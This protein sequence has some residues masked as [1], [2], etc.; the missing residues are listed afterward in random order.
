MIRLACMDDIEYLGSMVKSARDYMHSNGN[1][2]QWNGVY[3][4]VDD[5]KYHIEKGDLYV[6]EI[7]DEI[8]FAFVFSLE[9]DPNYAYIEDGNWLNEEPYGVFHL[10]MSSR[11]VRH[12]GDEMVG[13]GKL[14]ID[15]LRID[16]HVNN[17]PMRKLV[18]RN[19]FKYV[20]I[21]YVEDGTPRNAYQWSRNL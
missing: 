3:P 5:V 20:G 19:G 21:I 18:E 9:K 4:D 1:P 16:T 6:I 15:N 11:N 10:V 12:L 13:F 14:K 17:M 2:N 8:E 7:D